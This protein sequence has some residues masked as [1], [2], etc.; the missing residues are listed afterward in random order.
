MDRPQQ[1]YWQ[2]V[3]D[4]L[5]ENGGAEVVGASGAI[6]GSVLHNAD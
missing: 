5:A 6:V 1:A 2:S 4:T 3:E